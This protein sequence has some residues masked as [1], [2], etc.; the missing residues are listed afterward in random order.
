M[1]ERKTTE[2]FGPVAGSMLCPWAVSFWFLMPR[3]AAVAAIR[4]AHGW[5][6]KAIHIEFGEWGKSVIVLQNQT[7]IWN[8]SDGNLNEQQI[9]DVDSLVFTGQVNHLAAGIYDVAVC[10]GSNRSPNASIR[11]IA[12]PSPHVSSTCCAN[13]VTIP[14]SP[15]AAMRPFCRVCHGASNDWRQ[16]L[17]IAHEI[18]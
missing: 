1:R 5:P 9:R 11:P 4:T 18:G 10:L 16:R 8:C 17:S 12:G 6:W 14:V 13:C 3:P 7:S 15:Q 2:A